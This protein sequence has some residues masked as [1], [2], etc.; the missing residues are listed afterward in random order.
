M[1]LANLEYALREDTKEVP[2][3]LETARAQA[4]DAIREIRV[5][6]YLMHPPMLDE[7]GLEPT[8]RWYAR[9]FSERSGIETTFEVGGKIARLPQQVETTVFRIVQEALTNVHRYAGSRTATIH[10]SQREDELHVEIQDQVCGLPPIAQGPESRPGVG[11]AGMRE[12]VKQL[13]GAFEIESVAGRGTMVRAILPIAPP[14][15]A[16]NRE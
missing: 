16:V 7:L 3:H 2:R 5:L 1:T 15:H 12:R 6:S 10:L 11:I 13:N 4:E 14:N 8:I 9:G